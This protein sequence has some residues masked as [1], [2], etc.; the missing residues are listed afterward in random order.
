MHKT[1]GMALENKPLR[2]N[3]KK[4]KDSPISVVTDRKL[5]LNQHGFM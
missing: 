3:G 5:V 2:Q 4:K 1:T